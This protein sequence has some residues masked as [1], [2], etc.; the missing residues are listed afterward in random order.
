VAIFSRIRQFHP[1]AREQE[2]H[3][4]VEQVQ[5]VM[6][7]PGEGERKEEA[8]R[9]LPSKVRACR[10]HPSTVRIAEALGGEDDSWTASHVGHQDVESTSGAEV[11]EE[12]ASLIPSLL[13]TIRHFFGDFFPL[14]KKVKDPRE[15][16][17]IKYP[18]KALAFAGIMMF[19][20][21]LGSRR[22][23]GLLL[24]NRA[25]V[26]NCR[27]LFRTDGFPHGDTLNDTFSRVEP[28]EFQEIVCT[29]TEILIRKK[30]LNPWRLLGRRYVVAVDGTGVI[31]FK[32]RHC[33]HCLTQTQNGKTLYFHKV[34]EAKIVTPNGFAF[35]LM[36]EFIENAGEFVSKQDCELRAFYRLAKRLKKRFPRLPLCMSLDGLYAGG[37]TFEI[38]NRFDWKFIIVLKDD[39]LPYV[40][41]EFGSLSEMQ[42]E[43]T[44]TWLTGKRSEIRQKLLWV[45]NIHYV[46]SNKTAHS[47]SVMECGETKPSKQGKMTTTTF[48]WVTN[49]EVKSRTV[50][51]LANSG[52]RIRWKVENEGFNVQKN[53]GYGLEHAY[54]E[55]T[56]ALKVF[57][58]L[59]QIAHMLFQLLQKGSLLK[60]VFPRGCGSYKNLA[61]LILEA[62]R[63]IRLTCEQLKDIC[64]G[65][66]Q[67]R[68]DSS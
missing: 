64:A 22:Q 20:C 34:L 16:R 62:W 48:R 8:P 6:V 43:N 68:F 66:F 67:I 57:Y 46:D 41:Q 23:I 7:A 27:S 38:C 61:R 5:K 49:Y 44:L 11:E 30:V 54:S 63:T 2:S 56:N 36:T 45:N 40:N 12:L 47:V 29:M 13:S 31:T 55:N 4:S 39:S 9:R 10:P 58:F 14:F 59:M 19:L 65:G 50:I 3:G 35:S 53:G 25:S 37:P 1:A 52:G 24:R 15:P 28:D 26:E 42:P 32:E 17:K 33:P 60:K 18:M 51:E 21:H